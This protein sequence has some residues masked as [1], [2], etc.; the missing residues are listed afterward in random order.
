MPALTKSKRLNATRD[1]KNLRP[2]PCASDRGSAALAEIR[3]FKNC[4][5]RLKKV[6]NN[7]YHYPE[8]A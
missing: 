1:Q 3:K 6:D 2:W 5:Q 8:K 7:L 4:R